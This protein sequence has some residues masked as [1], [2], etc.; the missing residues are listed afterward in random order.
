[1][2][3][4]PERGELHDQVSPSAPSPGTRQRTPAGS[5]LDGGLPRHDRAGG[6]FGVLY[7]QQRQAQAAADAAALAGARDLPTTTTASTD[8]QTY[9]SANMPGANTPAVSFPT[10]SQ[11]KVVVSKTVPTSFGN[12]FGISSA[13]VSATA[14]AGLKSPSSCSAPGSN[15]YAMFASD[16]S[17]AVNGIT[18]GGG[19]HITGGVLSNG[20]LNVGGGGS[21]FGPTF[22]GAGC[23]VSPSGFQSQNKHLRLGTDAPGSNHH[24]ADRLLDRLPGLQRCRLYR[25]GRHAKLLHFGQHRGVGDPAVIQPGQPDLGQH[26]LR[27]GT[28]TASTPSTWNGA[29]TVSGTAEAT[30]VGGSVT[31][32]GGDNLTA[33]GYSTSGYTA[34]ACSSV[35]PAPATTNYPLVYAVQGCI[36]AS[37]GGDTFLGDMFAPNGTVTIGGGTETIFVEAKDISATGGGITGDGP[38]DAIGSSLSGSVALLQ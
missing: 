27:V 5:D 23:T 4:C 20:S 24:L 10:T 18:F 12:I 33:C 19:T 31:L 30:F 13:N 14:M 16:T 22:Y 9:V 36:D 37:G 7:Q 1:M 21:T 3:Q 25:P 15:C 17:C 32:S 26:L 35:V 8:A 6:R 29:I 2:S 28:G 11:I 38:S 34:S